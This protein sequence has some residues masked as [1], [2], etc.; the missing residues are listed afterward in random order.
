MDSFLAAAKVKWFNQNGVLWEAACEGSQLCDTDQ[1]CFKGFLAQYMGLTAILAPYTADGIF[2]LLAT[3][4]VAVGQHCMWGTNSTMCSGYW[5][6]TPTPSEYIAG[7][8]P[9]MSAL[10][11]FNANMLNPLFAAAGAGNATVVTN[12]TGGTSQGN[13]DAGSQQPT[14]TMYVFSHSS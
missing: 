7:V 9:Q 6:Q 10:N 12:S 4:A 5:T 2:S 13:P 11:V 3:S 14:L 8:G 1:L